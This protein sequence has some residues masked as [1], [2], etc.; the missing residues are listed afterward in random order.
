MVEKTKDTTGKSFAEQTRRLEAMMKRYL[1]RSYGKRCK[2]LS[3][4]CPVCDIWLAYD[5]IFFDNKDVESYVL[6]RKK[7]G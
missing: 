2:T 6:R 1:E 5:R 3:V 4:G 7:D